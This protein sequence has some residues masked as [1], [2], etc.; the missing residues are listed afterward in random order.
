[1]AVFLRWIRRDAS[2]GC[3]TLVNLIEREKT[4]TYMHTYIH[5]FIEILSFS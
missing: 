5:F 3:Q 2:L 4:V 1:M